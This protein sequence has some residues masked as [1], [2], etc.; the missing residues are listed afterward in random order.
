MFVIRAGL[1]KV[2]AGARLYAGIDFQFG[3]PNPYFRTTS[4]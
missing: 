2:D 3:K 1:T 4:I